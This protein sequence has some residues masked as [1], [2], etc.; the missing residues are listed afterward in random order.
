MN[1]AVHFIRKKSNLIPSYFSE[2]FLFILVGVVGGKENCG[3]G[4]RGRGNYSV[5]NNQENDFLYFIYV[6]TII[7]I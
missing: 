7:S 1:L 3:G 5:F 4:G 2:P 6:V